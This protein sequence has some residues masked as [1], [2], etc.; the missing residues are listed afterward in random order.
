MADDIT[1]QATYAHPP[2]Q[3]WR[4]LVRADLLGLWLMENDLDGEL[5]QGSRFAFRDRPRPFWDG[6]CP[7][8]VLEARPPQRLTLRW[9]ARPGSSS[10]SLVS[11]ALERTS[12]DGT[13]LTFRHSGLSGVMGWVMKKGMTKGWTQMVER[14]IPFVVDGLVRGVLPTREQIKAVQRASA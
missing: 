9:N 5:V 11:F 2:E 3:V 10:S 13:H 12:S 14:S 8:E 4:V 6:I 7:I 1:A